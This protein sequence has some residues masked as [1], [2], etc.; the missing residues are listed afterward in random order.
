MS[1]EQII[2]QPQPRKKWPYFA[3]GAAVLLVV[4]WV[5]Y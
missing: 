5:I 1:D 2:N 3:I 4:I